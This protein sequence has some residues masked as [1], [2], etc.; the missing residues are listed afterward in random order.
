VQTRVERVAPDEAAFTLAVDLLPSEA[1]ITPDIEVA[2]GRALAAFAARQFVVEWESRL[3]SAASLTLSAR[4]G[5]PWTERWRFTVGHIWHAEYRGLPSSPPQNPNPSL[6]APEYYPRPG[7]SLT[8]ALTRPEPAS[9]DT[10]AIDSVDYT[11]NVGAR[12]AQSNLDFAYRSTRGTEH[13]LGLPAG[14]E[15]ESVR[16]D[17]RAVPLELEDGRLSIPVTPGEHGVQVAWRNAQGADVSTALPRVDLGAGASNLRG[18][19]SLPAD[20]WVLYTSG[21]TLG[22]AVLYWAE[23]AIFALAAWVL[24]R[25]TLSPLRT[26]EWL[27]LGL[28]LSTFAWPVLLL[29]AA[30][31]FALSWRGRTEL[32]LSRFRFN[33]LQLGLGV[34]A[35][36]M[37]L[38]LVGSIPTGLLGQPDMQIASPVQFGALSWFADRSTGLTPE[39][40]VVSVS[41]WFYKAAML[42]W[43]LW[44]SFALLR[45]LRWAWRAYTSRGIWRAR[46]TASTTA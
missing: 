27:L 18:T 15:L 12:A 34:L 13:V 19:V 1:V 17:G 41:L 23:L 31:M 36:A 38:T 28:G 2:N 25:L 7:E 14:S 24:G 40:Q 32:D 39:A 26:H 10:I 6:F 29:F 44:L 33:S 20:R 5:A 3:P 37:L 43:A 30:T 42:A 21:P 8:V 11:H 45:W 9:G 16:I 22:P 46:D 4:A 35:V